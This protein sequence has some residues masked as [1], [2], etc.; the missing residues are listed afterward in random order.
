MVVPKHLTLSYCYEKKQNKIITPVKLYPIPY[1]SSLSISANALWDTGASLS[2]ITP[3]LM[4]KLKVIPVDKKLVA[5]VHTTQVVDIVLITV[6]LPNSVIKKNI[7][8]AVCNIT[9]NADVIIGMDIISL[10]DLALSNGNSQTFLSFASPSYKDKID[11]SKR[12][13]ED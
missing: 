9:S 12:Q 13:F 8:V 2:A 7:R 5:G 10:G 11:F 3:E 4:N 1:S 6:E